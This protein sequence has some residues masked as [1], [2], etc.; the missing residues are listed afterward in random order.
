MAP[1]LSEELLDHI[2]EGKEL[3]RDLSLDRLTKQG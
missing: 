2:E 1:L 3:S